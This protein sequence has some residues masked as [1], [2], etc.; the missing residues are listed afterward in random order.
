MSVSV[1]IGTQFGDEG[2]GKLSDYLSSKSDIVVRF[3]GG[4]NA[5]HTVVNRLGAFKLHLTPCG[6]FRENTISLI[7]SGTVVNPDVLLEEIRMLE[8][9]G[10]ITKN[11][12]ISSNANIL[13][14]Y[15]VDLDNIFEAGNLSIG[16]TKRGV[17]P[18]Y[19]DKARRIN[20]RF[21]DLIDLDKLEL[22]IEKAL[23][24]VNKVLSSYNYDTYSI[25]EIFELCSTW[26]YEFRDKIVDSI[27]LLHDALNQDKE[28]LF[29]GQLGVMKDIDF[30]IYPFVTSSHPIAAYAS[31][32]SGIPMNKFDNIIGVI[33]G[34]SSAV[35]EGPFPTE[36]KGEVAEQLRG[37]GENIDDEFGVRT[38]RARRVGWLDIPSLRYAN[39]ING[40]TQ[41]A[42]TKIDKLDRFSKI[43]ICVAY[44]HKG[45]EYESIPSISSLNNVKP[46]YEV[47]DGWNTST[48]KIRNYKNLP[49]KAKE[50]IK[51]IEKMV[52][53]K[54]KYIAN[55][56]ERENLI[57]RNEL[58]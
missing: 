42:L 48:D 49:S 2:K 31:V 15:H 46:I 57:V 30:G 35:G 25:K 23:S 50:Y 4:D 39:K 6:I 1:I 5:G 55:G 41:F 13:M 19:A 33:K 37:T 40:F 21:E 52:G 9:R 14:P 28:I 43:K 47:I 3:Q 36:I 38:G 45:K 7:G 26:S 44:M 58:R 8:S 27:N 24:F 11:L 34:F 20:I 22:K 53:V 54:I 17:G 16:T 56:P 10:V 32:S 18:A 29:E 51:R 12:R